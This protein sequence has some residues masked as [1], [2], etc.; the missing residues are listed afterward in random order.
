M[1]VNTATGV[2]S[3]GRYNF[4]RVTANNPLL[5]RSATAS[6]N[7]HQGLHFQLVLSLDWHLVTRWGPEELWNLLVTTSCLS[8]RSGWCSWKGSF[9]SLS[10]AST[11]TAIAL[12]FPRSGPVQIRS[13]TITLSHCHSLYLTKACIVLLSFWHIVIHSPQKDRENLWKP[14]IFWLDVLC[15]SRRILE[16]QRRSSFGAV[17]RLQVQILDLKSGQAVIKDGTRME[18]RWNIPNPDPEVVSR[19]ELRKSM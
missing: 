12:E 9:Q 15:C 18:H 16:T 10:S 1:T 14:V 17:E 7:L 6:S 3:T 11:P 19:E 4:V 8:S 2:W 5:R 13:L